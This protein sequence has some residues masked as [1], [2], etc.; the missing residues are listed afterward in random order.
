MVA[1][2]RPSHHQSAAAPPRR[3]RRH[4][5][6]PASR[7]RALLAGLA[8]T[9]LPAG[10]LACTDSQSTAG[11]E[12]GAQATL[13]GGS[14][15]D[16]AGGSGTTSADDTGTDG[17]GDGA[18]S[19][20]GA[21]SD[22]E[23]IGQP[24]EL[25]TVAEL[26]QPMVLVA[27]P[28]SDDLWVAQRAGEILRLERT[29]DADAGT[30]EIRLLPEPVLDLTGRIGTEGEGGLLGMAFS[31]AGDQLYLDYTDTDGDTVVSAF[32]LDGDTADPDDEQVLL[33]VDQPYSNHNGGDLQIG[34]DG[35]LYIALGDGGSADDPDGNGQDTSTL[36]G[37]LLRID[38]TPGGE[39]TYVV[40]GD[41]PFVDTPDARP[42]IWLYGARNP[43]RFSFDPAT[44]DLW[45]GDVGQNEWEEIDHLPASG[46]VGAGA[47]ANL[48]WN[49]MEGTHPFAGDPPADHVGPIHEY[50]HEA[51]ACSVTGGHVYRGGA[52]PALDGVYL[53][54]DY[55]T[56]GVAGIQVTADG[57]P[58]VAP[59]SLDTS[60]V[61]VVSFGRGPDGESY[62]LEQG[63]RV[64]RLQ[65]PGGGPTVT[66]SD[67]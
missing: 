43:W 26:V 58:V 7:P 59:L 63:G 34:P 35:L 51:G 49:L 28:G 12:G 61:N 31:P 6:R 44:G 57:E 9:V 47:G 42:E 3:H 46:G 14:S 33:T 21:T 50:P 2:I 13:P 37:T 67:G 38:P 29:V 45:V 18:T 20:S 64:S 32:A 15:G 11:D 41:N 36:L 19:T 55:C 30:E 17:S 62:V 60:P 52:I 4:G 23:W 27:R 16:T 10:A 56:G 39:A 40:P 54:S 48:G 22:A 1:M 25:V 53:F 8:L 66:R 65:A 5:L 24:V